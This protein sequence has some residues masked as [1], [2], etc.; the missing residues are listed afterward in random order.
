MPESRRRKR[1]AYTAPTGTTSLK[2]RPP[3]PPWVGASI[4]ALFVIGIVYLVLYYVTGGGVLGQ[5]HLHGWNILIGFG[6]IVAGF[7]MLTQ[8][9]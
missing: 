6:F 2:K 5:Q 7:A 1:T 3:S 9:N 4:L 8:W